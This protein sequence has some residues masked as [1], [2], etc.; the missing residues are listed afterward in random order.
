MFRVW[1]EG[2]NLSSCSRRL[3]GGKE[4]GKKK[5]ETTGKPKLWRGATSVLVFEQV[6]EGTMSRLFPRVF[7]RKKGGGGWRRGRWKKCRGKPQSSRHLILYPGRGGEG[8]GEGKKKEKRPPSQAKIPGGRLAV[9]FAAAD[10]KKGK[11][12]EE[13]YLSFLNDGG[14]GGH[15]NCFPQPF[16][17]RSW[18]EK[19]GGK[20][21]EQTENDRCLP[22]EKQLALP[23]SF[24]ANRFLRGGKKKKKRGGGKERVRLGRRS[25]ASS[26]RIS[27]SSVRSP[28]GGERGKERFSASRGCCAGEKRKKT[29]EADP[30]TFFLQ[31]GAP[32]GEERKGSRTKTPGSRDG[33]LVRLS[34]AQRQGRMEG[35][36]K[37]REGRSGGTHGGRFLKV[38]NST[39]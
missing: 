21:G 19:E 38:I 25:A 37:K 12:R 29:V 22:K 4:G 39:N 36:G 28:R 33:G 35:E 8:G 3:R 1:W 26:W 6:E 16:S 32:E 10:F 17:Y 30:H 27:P 9:I 13:R 34:F 14:G 15:P 18:E 24:P 23:H 5:R 20:G 31:A 7:E 2:S 11:R